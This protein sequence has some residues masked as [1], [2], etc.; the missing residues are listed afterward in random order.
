M[1]DYPYMPN[2]GNLKKFFDYIQSGGV[3]DKLTRKYLES[4]GFKSKNDR[5]IIPIL[6]FIGFLDPSGVPTEPWKAY[7]DKTQ[8]RMV[9]AQAIR[10]AY[11]G[12]FGTYP[13]ADRKDTEALRNY[14]SG[15]TS[16]AAGAVTQVVG[17]FKTLCGLGDFAGNAVEAADGS[18]KQE[19]LDGSTNLEPKVI[20]QIVEV[21][22]KGGGLTINLNI[23]LQLPP[24]DDA[25]VYD[26]LFASMKKHL[27]L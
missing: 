5:K 24:T 11:S 27:G 12:L 2:V 7:R 13:D 19:P 8:A 21:P 18:T 25:S 3:P 22:A 16:L 10:G 26:K 9:L 4:V 17:T 1:A 15:Q 23:Q 14:F 20:K 6:R